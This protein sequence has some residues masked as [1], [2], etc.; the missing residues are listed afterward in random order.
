MIDWQL[1]I[2][3][4]EQMAEHYASARS[5]IEAEAAG[6][7]SRAARAGQLAMFGGG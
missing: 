2:P 6:S 7:D 3:G 1:T 5:R 4:V